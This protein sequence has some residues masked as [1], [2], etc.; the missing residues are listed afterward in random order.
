M[1]IPTTGTHSGCGWWLSGQPQ[2]IVSWVEDRKYEYSLTLLN[3]VFNRML[4][5]INGHNCVIISAS[6]NGNSIEQNRDSNLALEAWLMMHY[7]TIMLEGYFMDIDKPARKQC[8]LV[9]TA[10]FASNPSVEGDDGGEMFR[11]VARVAKHFGQESFFGSTPPNRFHSFKHPYPRK[12]DQLIP[13]NTCTRIENA[14]DLKKLIKSYMGKLTN[15]TNV[16]TNVNVPLDS[17]LKIHAYRCTMRSY[18]RSLLINS[19]GR[20]LDAELFGK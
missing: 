8:Q 10:L 7:D 13:N 2:S 11:R 1:T 15:S 19:R 17:E 6:I 20:R 12:D 9:E 16:S 14:S 4:W 18:F 5:G 3:D